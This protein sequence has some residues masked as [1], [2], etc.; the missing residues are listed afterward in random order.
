MSGSFK[1]SL[2]SIP[3]YGCSY[4]T[5]KYQMP[6][7]PTYTHDPDSHYSN[8]QDA[9]T[10]MEAY[11]VLCYV[12]RRTHYSLAPPCL[13]KS[14][15]SLWFFSA[16]YFIAVLLLVSFAAGSAPLSSSNLIASFRPLS[17]ADINAV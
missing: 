7:P 9:L 2:F 13:S 1:T 15:M 10:H 3:Q 12:I 5:V 14:T 4:P 16:A 6:I 8:D 17:A 11:S